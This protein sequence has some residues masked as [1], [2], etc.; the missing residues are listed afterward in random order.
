MPDTRL[1]PSIGCLLVDDAMPGTANLSGLCALLERRGVRARRF[2][3]SAGRDLH[4]RLQEAYYQARKGCAGQGIV[5]RGAGC[6]AALA[7]AEQLP[8][9][10]LI[11]IGF[12]APDTP[13]R[14]L[15]RLRAFALRNLSF[16]VCDALLID[17]GRPGFARAVRRLRGLRGR[18]FALRVRADWLQS[19][20][21]SAADALSLFLQSGELP[22][23]LAENHEMCIIYG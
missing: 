16:C 17:E 5:A 12:D 7:L 13:R 8:V 2:D 4:G 9:D 15:A 14:E 21:E 3:A 10:R 18:Q 23:Y 20:P 1:D 11:L 19:R 6:W 22:K